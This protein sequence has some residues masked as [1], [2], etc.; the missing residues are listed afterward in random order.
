MWVRAIGLCGLSLTGLG[1]LAILFLPFVSVASPGFP[2]ASS[3]W[4]ER[5][6][7]ESGYSLRQILFT[8]SAVVYLPMVGWVPSGL[9]P[10]LRLVVAPSRSVWHIVASI[11]HLIWLCAFAVL[12]LMAFVFTGMVAAPGVGAALNLGMAVMSVV[13]NAAVLVV[14]LVVAVRQRR[15]ASP[16]PGQD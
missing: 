15:A 1:C 4:I 12:Y 9:L 10:W 8:E 13:L 7:S 11:G 6:L 16:E 3:W 2:A 5:A 14:F